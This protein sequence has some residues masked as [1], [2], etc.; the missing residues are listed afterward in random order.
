[1]ELPSKESEVSPK[2]I[3]AICLAHGLAALW[4]KIR[5]DPPINP[6]KSDGCS[7]WLYTWNVYDLNPACCLQDLKYWAGYPDDAVERLIADAELVIDVARLLKETCMAEITF[8]GIR[9]GVHP[10]IKCSFPWGFGRT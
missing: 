4:D 3:K 9:V 1:M 5:A 2:R 7:K 8:N 6:F 10:A